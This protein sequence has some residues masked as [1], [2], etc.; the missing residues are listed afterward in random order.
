MLVLIKRFVEIP[1]GI[2]VA[3]AGGTLCGPN[4]FFTE[5]GK[6][7]IL[8]VDQSFFDVVG[9]QLWFRLTGEESAAR[10]LVI[11]P[12][13]E[14]DRRVRVSQKVWLAGDP[15][16]AGFRRDHSREGVNV[17]IVVADQLDNSQRNYYQQDGGNDSAAD[18]VALPALGLVCFSLLSPAAAPLPPSS[19][20]F[21]IRHGAH[22]PFF[23]NEKLFRAYPNTR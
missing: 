5:M 14:M 21:L 9:N 12:F 20:L 19:R 11:A 17:V 16:V 13:D 15:F 10:S 18:H 22:Q 1:V 23:R 4:G 3:R 2:L 8:Q 6:I 7:A